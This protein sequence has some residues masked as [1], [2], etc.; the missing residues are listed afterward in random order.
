MTDELA[1]EKLRCLPAGGANKVD[2]NM[3]TASQVFVCFAF[4]VLRC[5]FADCV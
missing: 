1:L 2:I 4:A 5:V 3:E